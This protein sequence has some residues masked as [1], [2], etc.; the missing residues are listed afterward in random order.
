VAAFRAALKEIRKDKMPLGWAKTQ[1]SLGNTL[2]FSGYAR[3]GR[4]GWNRP[5]RPIAQR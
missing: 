2:F 3:P 4:R 1:N 5:W